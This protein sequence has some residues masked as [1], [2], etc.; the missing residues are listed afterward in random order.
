MGKYPTEPIKCWNRAKELRG[1]Y[2]DSIKKA[3]ENGGLIMSGSGIF[4]K[5]EVWHAVS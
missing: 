3:R 1:K 2:Y 5:I 4:V